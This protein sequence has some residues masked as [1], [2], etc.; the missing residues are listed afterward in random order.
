MEIFMFKFTAKDSFTGLDDGKVRE[1]IKGESYETADFSLIA[2]AEKIITLN[3]GEL[4]KE[5]K[6]SDDVNVDDLLVD[7]AEETPTP[8]GRGRKKGN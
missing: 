4:P 5:I 1:F 8:K 2:A 6:A 7:D 3:K